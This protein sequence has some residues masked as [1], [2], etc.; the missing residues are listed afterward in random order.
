MPPLSYII[1]AAVLA[2]LVA[3]LQV[4]GERGVEHAERVREGNLAEDAHFRPFARGA[5]EAGEIAEAV[6]GEKRRLFEWRD[7]K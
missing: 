3:G 7:E 4:L 2:V 5:H 1:T 6:G